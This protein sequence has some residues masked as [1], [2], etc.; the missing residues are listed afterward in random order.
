MDSLLWPFA[1]SFQDRRKQ[2]FTTEA[3][4]RE[5]TD[6]KVLHI[7][8]EQRILFHLGGLGRTKGAAAGFLP[9]PDF[10]LGCWLVSEQCY[11]FLQ[12]RRRRLLRASVNS[13]TRTVMTNQ[14]TLTSS[15]A[16]PDFPKKEI[17]HT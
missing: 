16:L 13:Q 14:V 15:L 10:A 17:K 1:T 6:T 4:T 3:T 8:L 5:R 12:E 2:G 9:V 7:S 11:S